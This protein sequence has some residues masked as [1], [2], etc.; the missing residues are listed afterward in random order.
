MKLF[1]SS[2]SPLLVYIC[3]VGNLI[4]TPLALNI[5]YINFIYS[6]LILIYNRSFQSIRTVYTIPCLYSLLGC[7]NV[8]SKLASPELSSCYFLSTSGLPPESPILMGNLLIHLA[9]QQGCGE[10]VILDTTCLL[11]LVY[12][13]LFILCFKYWIH[14]PLSSNT[15]CT[16]V[17]AIMRVQVILTHYLPPFP[18]S[19]LSNPFQLY[20]QHAIS[21][22]LKLQFEYSVA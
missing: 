4:H 14:P 7:V 1:C 9:F 11:L 16:L 21:K 17:Q 20:N 19:L 12:T 15:T 13:I 6:I 22:H 2:R 8:T 5:I 10:W 18:S 3:S